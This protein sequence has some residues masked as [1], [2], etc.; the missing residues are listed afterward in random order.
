MAK[1]TT[2]VICVLDD[3]SSVLNAVVRLLSLVGWRVKEFSDPEEFLLH[4][5]LYGAAV[6]IVDVWM[7]QM[8]GL[9][10]QSRLR[11]L[12]PSTQVI[13]FTGKDDSEVRATALNAGAAAYLTKPLDADQ[14]LN[15]IRFALAS[16]T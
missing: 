13:I 7:P 3:D 16:T 11:D 8:N 4:V 14:L 12:S 9:E 2:D 10:V 15:A 1:P 5:K 6:A